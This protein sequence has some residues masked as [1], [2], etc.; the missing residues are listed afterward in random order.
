MQKRAHERRSG[1]T[2]IEMLIVLVVAMVLMT[3]GIPVLRGT[4]LR[5]QVASFATQLQSTFQSARF[6]AI[7]QGLP[8]VVQIVPDEGLVR[9]YVDVPAFDAAGVRTDTPFAL[10]PE[11]GLQN[12]E[13]DRVL[14]QLTTPNA[15]IFDA[16]AGEDTVVGMTNISGG[17]PEDADLSE[18][19]LVF[20]ADG[21]V[22]ALGAFRFAARGDSK[23]FL[24]ARLDFAATGKSSLLKYD[25]KDS[26]WRLRDEDVPGRTN[27]WEW[28]GRFSGGC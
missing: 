18:R 16:P 14:L 12:I 13:T 8:V 15:V 25:C 20:N 10:E 9:T 4:L 27:A 2:L 1:F 19:V 23:N 11:P 6:E 7:K 17:A 3:I 28:Y 22:Q 26:V 5:A 24:E 21:A